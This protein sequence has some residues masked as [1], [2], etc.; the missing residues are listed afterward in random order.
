MFSLHK[1]NKTIWILIKREHREKKTIEF[2]FKK[3]KKKKINEMSNKLKTRSL[4]L[5][6][7][8]VL[9]KCTLFKKAQYSI[10]LVKLSFTMF[11]S[12]IK[13][14]QQ[15]DATVQF[16][17]GEKKIYLKRSKKK[18]PL[19][20]FLISSP[21]KITVFKLHFYCRFYHCI[22]FTWV[23]IQSVVTK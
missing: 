15:E 3:K 1:K 23:S 11:D 9:S 10:Q 17:V 21:S 16:A 8:S 18:P 14:C 7:N 6:R 2:T 12:E 20:L 4:K 22:D 5:L 13:P 19:H